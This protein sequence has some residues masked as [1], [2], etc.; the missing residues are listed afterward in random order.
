MRKHQIWLTIIMMYHRVNI[1][2]PV[3]HCMNLSLNIVICW[4]RLLRYL[5]EA[6]HHRKIKAML[7]NWLAYRLHVNVHPM[8]YMCATTYKHTNAIYEIC[9][10][11]VL[12]PHGNLLTLPIV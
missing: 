8:D 9:V 3:I 7:V 12:M 4:M 1:N 6:T 10:V 5:R 11:N 2:Y